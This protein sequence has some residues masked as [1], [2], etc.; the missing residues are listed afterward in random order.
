METKR[1]KLTWDTSLQ[2]TEA[3]KKRLERI[4]SR[5]FLRTTM[6]QVPIGK[7][8]FSILKRMDNG[9]MM[10]VQQ[11]IES[12]DEETKLEYGVITN[13]GALFAKGEASQVLL[14]RAIRR[15]I[16]IGQDKYFY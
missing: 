10:T 8:V 11:L 1:D 16:S 15:C 9:D 4:Q 13:T 14:L 2:I 6:E 12:L 7:T 3:G 5:Y